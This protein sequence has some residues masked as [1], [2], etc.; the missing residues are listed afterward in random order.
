M[1]L[2]LYSYYRSSASYRVRIALALKNLPFALVPVNLLKAEQKGDAYLALNP[3]GLVPA[4]ADEAGNILTQ[5]LAIMEYLEETH[6]TPSLLPADALGR[7]RVRALALAIACDIAPINNLAVQRR[8][9][10]QFKADDDAKKQWVRHWITQGLGAIE[11]TLQNSSETGTFCHGNT[12]TFADCVLIPQLYNA[13]RF[14]CDLTPYPTIRRIAATCEALK[15][16]QAAHPDHQ[17]DKV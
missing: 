8:L 10:Q 3:Q 16:F 7:A 14:E 11:K 4:L 6:P 15:A 9:E 17:P 12:P 1:T 13:K 2:T 5:S